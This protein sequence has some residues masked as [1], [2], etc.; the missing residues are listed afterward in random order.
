MSNDEKKNVGRAVSHDAANE[1]SNRPGDENYEV[2]Y[3]K[4]PKHTQFA[5]G[6]SGNPRG[7]PRKHQKRAVRLSDAPLD[8]FLEM[9]AYRDISLRENGQP[10]SLSAAQAVFR[11]LVAE[12]IKGKRLHQKQFIELLKQAENTHSQAKVD[13]YIRLQE[14]KRAGE[15]RIEECRRMG[16]PAPDLVPHPDDIVL[17]S[18]TGDAYVCG[19]ETKEDVAYYEQA[20]RLRDHLVLQS[21]HAEKNGKTPLARQGDCEECLFL[22]F[23]HLIDRFLPTRFQWTDIEAISLMMDCDSLNKRE[24]QRQVDREQ[25]ELKRNWKKPSGITPEIAAEMERVRRQ[26]FKPT[27]RRA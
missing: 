16:L 18:S 11:S 21:V 12:A 23:A 25:D 5:K 7:R 19:P 4:P 3:G 1:A 8:Q 13:H 26:F 20:I 27:E 17:N 2:G 14:E 22:V 24:R 15:R 6:Q 10:I 9:E